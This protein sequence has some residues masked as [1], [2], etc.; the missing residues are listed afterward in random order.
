[1][2]QLWPPSWAQ[3]HFEVLGVYCAEAQELSDPG[4]GVP[5]PAT[6]YPGSRDSDQPSHLVFLVRYILFLLGTWCG[7]FSSRGPPVSK[8]PTAN[9]PQGLNVLP[10]N[11]QGP[12]TP[13][14]RDIWPKGSWV[15]KG[16]LRQKGRP[17][18]WRPKLK[19]KGQLTQAYHSE[20]QKPRGV[21]PK[22]PGARRWCQCQAQDGKIAGKEAFDSG[23]PCKHPRGHE[24]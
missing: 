23:H 13:Y 22:V 4:W 21:K 20:V 17:W 3:E 5:H 9:R 12:P 18:V 15:E 19:G 6:K 16:A 2:G 11:S 24:K 14:P 7:H 1:M 8:R 10:N